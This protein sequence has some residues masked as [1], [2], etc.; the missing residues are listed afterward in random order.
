MVNYSTTD[1]DQLWNRIDEL[2]ISGPDQVEVN[3]IFAY[4]NA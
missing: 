1:I 3:N 4:L 2:G